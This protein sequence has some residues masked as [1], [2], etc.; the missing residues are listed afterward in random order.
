[1]SD[2]DDGTDTKPSR[3][4]RLR[5]I[6]LVLVLLAVGGLA[7]TWAWLES[8]AGQDRMRRW[9]EARGTAV[10][11]RPVSIARLDW[12]LLPFSAEVTGI[13]VAGAPGADEPLVRIAGVAVRIRPWALLSRELLLTS[14]EVD[15]P[16]VHWDADSGS[17]L[18]LEAGGGGSLAVTVERLAIND[19]TVEINHRRWNLDSSLGGVNL[20]LAPVAGAASS[21]R[22]TGMLRVGAGSL[23][24][25]PPTG[26]AA[27]PVG[28]SIELLAA[29]VP[30]A[31][32]EDRLTI[33]PSRLALGNSEL[34]ASGTIGDW[35][36]VALRIGG[37]IDVTDV[38]GLLGLPTANGYS[39]S[40]TLDATLTYGPEPLQVIGSVT[41][42]AMSLASIETTELTADVDLTAERVRV[43]DLRLS[44]FDGTLIADVAVELTA[45][46]RRWSVEYELSDVDMNALSNSPALPGFRIAGTASAAGSLSWQ[47]PIAE[48][49]SGAGSFDLTVPSGTLEQL[50][51]R[52][53]ESAAPRVAGGVATIARGT[54]DDAAPVQRIAPSLPLP[55]SAHA[56]YEVAAGAVTINNAGASLP[57]NTATITGT[58]GGDGAIAAEVVIDSRDLRILDRFFNQI[59]RF[60]GEEPVPQP[61][62]LDG[63]GRID[64]ILGGN[65]DDP[66]VDGTLAARTLSVAGNPVG[67]I[68]GNLRL[69]GSSLRL[70]DLRLR[71]D[72]GTGEG[73]GRLRIGAQVGTGPD[74][75]FG[76]RLQ[77]YPMQV[78]LPRLGMPLSA[79]GR[80][81]GEIELS[82]SYGGP[83]IGLVTLDSESLRLNELENLRAQVRIRLAE[84]AWVAEQFEISAPSGRITASG[85]WLR[86][87]DAVEAQLDA[88]DVDASFVGD[89]TELETPL[90][91]SLQLQALLTGPFASPDA[92]ATLRWTDAS[93]YD[94]N[95]GAVAS[96]AELRGRT[97]AVSAVGRSEPGAPAVPPPT[98]TAAGG[99]VAV[100]L[101][102]VPAGGWAASLSA[103]LN[104]PRRATV[105][106]AGASDLLLALLAA[107]G[108][109]TGGEVSGTIEVD[110]N[111]VLGQWAGWDG[112]ATL[113]DFAMS[114]P[115]LSF[116][117]PEPLQLELDG[118]LL[119]VEL[120]QLVSA[121]GSLSARGV[122]DTKT[123]RWRDASA[124]GEVSLGVLGALS[125]ELETEG[126]LV[127]DMEASGE[128]LAGNVTGSFE[129]RG[130]SFSHADSPWGARD[131][132]GTIRL[133][134]NH[135]D[136]V[137]VRG[138]VS[139][140][141]FS[142]DGSVPLAAIAG[143][144]SSEPF[145]LA[146]TV[147]S[148]PLEPLWE[149][150][151]ALSELIAG[152]EA[153]VVATVSGR[154]TDWR[155]YDGRIEVRSLRVDLTD[156]TL[157]TSRSAALEINGD[158]LEIV[159]PILLQGPG[160]DLR[161]G[162]AFLFAPFRLD[163][164]LDGQASLDPLNDIT[165]DWGVA[166]RTELDVRIAGAPPD[167]TF[168]G[169]MSVR[170]GL[171][172]A[173]V[174]Q[175]IENVSAELTL[176]NRLIRIE[177][178]TGSLG[179]TSATRTNV[180]AG[181]EIQLA[182]SVPRSFVLNLDVDE[183][184]LRLQQGVRANASA[185]LLLEGS[186]ERSLLSGTMN[187]SEGEYTQRWDEDAL[188]GLS[189]S[190]R[191]SGID[192]PLARSMSLDIDLV[193]PGNLR[194]NNN[195]AD[196]EL[197][198]DLQVRGTLADPV[199]LG[200]TTVLDGSA[201]FRDQRYRF[202]RGSIEFQ[203]PLRTE[204][205][206]D[207]AMETSIRQ[208]FVTVIASGSP[209]R[210][211]VEIDFVSSPPLSDLQLIQLLTV[212]SAPDDNA[213]LE[214]VTLGAVGAQATSFLTRQYLS[215]VERGAQQVF[216][217]D[218]FQIE[219]SV[220]D[221]TGDPTARV[222]F[223]K[224]VTAALW[225]SWT[226]V[227]GTTD[228]QLVSAEYQLT[229]GI[230]LTATREEDGSIGVDIRFDLRLR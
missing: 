2:A 53:S 217:I 54:G 25:Q 107:Q 183:A 146:L 124:T 30:F 64:A 142:I 151:G 3:G 7:G 198:A 81:S 41:S 199:L 163:T 96:S 221:G 205:S 79:A 210:G 82:G 88:V 78:E 136:L 188:L 176:E 129:L 19:G 112:S 208:Y 218:R 105:R 63:A 23:S 152:G 12:N 55:V 164:T 110:G 52:T 27:D 185:D 229:R 166:G 125:D 230:R 114:R 92:A 190:T 191:A 86:E 157:S 39:G 182:D 91:G 206:F 21:P 111:G 131:L 57:N 1:M 73:Q 76:L 143:E 167:L 144:D 17:N 106:A 170:E 193:A 35:R 28:G 80:T 6:L 192:H 226:T 211:D 121:A 134:N 116:S 13:E 117:I 34:S 104:D 98:P 22:R 72:G 156:L 74:Y 202:Q 150:T 83:P 177:S 154:G 175:P 15:T 147:D 36:D 102:N 224:Q 48:T 227:L 180:S 43:D 160:T 140:R 127:V 219:P 155:T 195:M 119:S 130:V 65:L 196:V 123:R 120:P 93:V 90:G 153:S 18:A 32:G 101:D 132:S 128:V 89:L 50:A 47:E 158:R 197:S 209:A 62:G 141:P 58:I 172:N 26:A 16:V 200:R 44:S 165:R 5:R 194:I 67:D 189:G 59:R 85:R 122:I 95:L 115:D 94:I 225:I 8:T 174:L 184:S 77:D 139:D 149:R 168:D 216:G 186:L 159:E 201:V 138:L 40:V 148:L 178:F 70:V 181:G 68:D 60:R 75:S 222:T 42:P 24:L 126:T 37:V 45:Q 213:D 113:T 228:E 133:A 108:Y 31:V 212:G 29:E 99:D 46:P 135:L 66:V 173:P 161:V 103:D 84:D 187:I 171:L 38:V 33:E 179:T 14:V 69:A 109:E 204:P 214:N 220:T 71:R 4:R 215:Q 11:Q 9:L 118:G 145:E 137:D 51:R 207:I 100:P 203:N 97:I 162:G 56:E 10:L 61:F 49:I 87:A 223:G 20:R 169:T